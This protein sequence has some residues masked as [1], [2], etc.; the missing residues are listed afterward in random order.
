MTAKS[1]AADLIAQA[2]APR[3]PLPAALRAELAK[4][5][6]HNDTSPRGQ[7]VSRDQALALC[8]SHGVEMEYS[9]FD[10]IIQAEFS[11][12]WGGA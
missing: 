8:K 3:N 5:L 4:L 12:K 10:R 1:T 6:K 11:R 9:K 7:R 2:K